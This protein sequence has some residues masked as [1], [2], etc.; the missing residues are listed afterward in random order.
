MKESILSGKRIL[1]IDDEPDI[2]AVIGEEILATCPD[3]KVDKAPAYKEAV[4]KM[5]SWTYDLVILDI[6]CVR[7]FDLLELANYRNFPVV[8]LTAHPLTS[9]VLQSSFK[10]N[11]RA[12]LPKERLGEVVPLVE[13]IITDGYQHVRNYLFKKMRDFSTKKFKSNCHKT[14]I[15]ELPRV[16]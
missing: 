14:P 13:N 8:M 7:G 11:A 12:Y 1:V 3:C 2:H 4:E 5:I 9:R 16:N 10:M 6:T 15:F